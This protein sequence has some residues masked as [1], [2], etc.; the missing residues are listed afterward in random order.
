MDIA[1]PT[2]MEAIVSDVSNDGFGD[3]RW[4][5]LV[6]TGD[7][8]VVTAGRMGLTTAVLSPEREL[9]RTPV[10]IEVV[11]GRLETAGTER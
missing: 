1:D 3:R 11:V 9:S 10:L 5:V 6:A 4:I 8:A 2:W 7:R